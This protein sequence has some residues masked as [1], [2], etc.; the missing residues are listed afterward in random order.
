MQE[1]PSAVPGRYTV[2]ID[3]LEEMRWSWQALQAAPADLVE[4]IAVR[5]EARSKWLQKRAEMDR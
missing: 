5:I 1:I 3:I 2:E 4:E